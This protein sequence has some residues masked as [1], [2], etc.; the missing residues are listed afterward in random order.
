MS[1][2]S[3]STAIPPGLEDFVP[4]D[5]FSEPRSK[6]DGK[7]LV[8]PNLNCTMHTCMSNTLKVDNSCT[9]KASCNP[10]ATH[11][12][13]ANGENSHL[14]FETGVTFS[15]TPLNHYP[16]YIIWTG[17]PYIYRKFTGFKHNPV[18]FP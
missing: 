11:E 5:G 8:H 10:F 2:A 9:R 13:I 18:N 14:N 4:R 1:D 12:Y 7:Y 15:N 3:D 6:L 16:P 17:I